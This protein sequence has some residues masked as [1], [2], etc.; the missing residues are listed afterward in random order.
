MDRVSST[1]EVVWAAE[2]LDRPSG[3]TLRRKVL[4]DV[5]DC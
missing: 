3:Q 1:E 2:H 4:E 5:L